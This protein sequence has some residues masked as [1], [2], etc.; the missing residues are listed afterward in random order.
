MSILLDPHPTLPGEQWGESP[1]PEPGP[2]K[3]SVL[4]PTKW[5]HK[6]PFI[7]CSGNAPNKASASFRAF[8]EPLDSWL[9]FP[10]SVSVH[11]QP[12][13]G[14]QV[15]TVFFSNI[16]PM[17]FLH[18]VPHCDLLLM[19]CIFRFILNVHFRRFQPSIVYSGES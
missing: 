2:L 14:V 18:S 3:A 9:H 17:G 7:L 8:W 13:P 1:P 6:A 5:A 11:K 16:L 19:T 10:E 4:Q 15:T 12:S